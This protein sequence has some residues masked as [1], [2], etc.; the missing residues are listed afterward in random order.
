MV[1]NEV[2]V[3]DKGLRARANDANHLICPRIRLQ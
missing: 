1:S 3:R 2:R